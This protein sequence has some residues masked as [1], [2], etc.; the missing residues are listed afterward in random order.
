MS[1]RTLRERK[2]LSQEQLAEASGLS[3]R[4]IQRAEAGHRVS[5]ASLRALA[6]VFEIDVD[7]LERKLYASSKSIDD[8]FVEVP[9]W[10]RVLNGEGWLKGPFPG[11]RDIHVLEAALISLA[12]IH[13]VA[14]V[15]ATSETAIE[16]HR[17]H[18]FVQLTVCY[19]M[20]IWVRAL[21]AKKLWPADDGAAY[22]KE[23][24]AIFT[25]KLFRG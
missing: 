13:L 22:R 8:D 9:R 11:R 25:K 18:A 16:M 12:V 2:L 14:S 23:L 4:T 17:G 20:S 19:L 6:A 15:L 3:L 21:D 7:Q 1:I 24:K 5:Y 10:L